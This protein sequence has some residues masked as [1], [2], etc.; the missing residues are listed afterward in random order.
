M[1]FFV[2]ILAL[3]TWSLQGVLM[4]RFYRELDPWAATGVRGLTLG[5]SMLPLLAVVPSEAYAAL[6]DVWGWVVV[7]CA[8]A[9]IGNIC[10]AHAY[11]N[12]P[13]GIASASNA[14]LRAVCGALLGYWFLHE[15]LSVREVLGMA[16]VLASVLLLGALKSQ[17]QTHFTVRAK[18]G[19]F[20]SVLHAPFHSIAFVAV[21][22]GSRQT[23]PFLIG[24]VWEIGIGAVI[25]VLML[26][27]PQRFR[28]LAPCWRHFWKILLCSSPTLVGTACYA[29]APTHGSIAMVLTVLS[30]IMLA[31]ATYAWLIYREKLTRTQLAAMAFVCVMLAC[32]RYTGVS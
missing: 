27:R 9:A 30:T 15:T 32:F 12:L 1:A 8:G 14:S 24:Y 4:A 19:L 29:W 28:P 20:F 2:A 13:V 31:S 11:A 16:G 6:P 21:A 18:K 22:A 7:A 23:H 25:I 3:L 26:F 10:I 5:I 17:H